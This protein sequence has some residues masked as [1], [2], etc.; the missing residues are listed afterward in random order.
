MNVQVNNDHKSDVALGKVERETYF[1]KFG[2]GTVTTSSTTIWIGSTNQ[3]GLYQWID[4]DTPVILDVFSTDAGDTTQTIEISGLDKHWKKQSELVNVNGAT[5]VQTQYQYIRINRISVLGGGTLDGELHVTE[6]GT[7]SPIYAMIGDSGLD[8]N[9]TQQCLFTVPAGY[10]IL[11]D[12]AEMT[13]YNDKKTNLYVLDRDWAQAEQ[14]GL[15]DPPFR[16]VL[17][18]NM[19]RSPHETVTSVP[20]NVTER[21]DIEFRGYTESGTDFVTAMMFGEEVQL[22]SVPIDPTNFLATPGTNEVVL[23]WDMLTPAESSDQDWFSLEYGP[24]GGKMIKT[25]LAKGI[26][27]HTVTALETGVEYTFTLRFNGYDNKLS[28]GVTDTAT[29]L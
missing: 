29:V 21:Q 8:R 20:F 25:S 4:K 11:I 28:T 15:T 14:Y 3:P 13:L 9:R 18:W 27:T 17:N 26:D 7:V 16:I 10:S 19:R 1:W 5:A 12:R 24:V 22:Y 2:E 23:T 6:Q